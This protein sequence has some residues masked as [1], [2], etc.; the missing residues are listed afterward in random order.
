[1][2]TSP[3]V[4]NALYAGVMFEKLSPA[5]VELL[6]WL[7]AT[8]NGDI[9]AKYDDPYIESLRPRYQTSSRTWVKLRELGLIE[10][11]SVFKEYL[12]RLGEEWIARDMSPGEKHRPPRSVYKPS[13]IRKETPRA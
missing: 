13:R 9:S 11:G 12:T 7:Y 4:E 10:R 8:N 1:M 2:A 5:Q 6:Y 3:E